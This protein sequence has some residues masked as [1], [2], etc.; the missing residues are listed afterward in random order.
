M[1]AAVVLAV[2][3]YGGYFN[4]G[5]GIMLLAAFGLIGYRSLHGMNGLKN[6]LSVVLSFTSAIVFCHRWSDRLG[7][8]A[9]YGGKHCRGRVF[10][11]PLEPQDRENRSA[12]SFRDSCRSG[13]DTDF[14][15]ELKPRG[16]VR[17]LALTD[18]PSGMRTGKDYRAPRIV[19]DAAL[20]LPPAKRICLGCF[21]VLNRQE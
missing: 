16:C 19:K 15:Y 14:L 6:M 8:S 1:S 18:A 7:A 10:G 17:R 13:N 2:S 20:C 9:G 11:C 3:D 12:A 4:V 21:I 5:L